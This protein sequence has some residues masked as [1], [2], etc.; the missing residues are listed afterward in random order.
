[1]ILELLGELK[2]AYEELLPAGQ[3]L[4]GVKSVKI[5]D[6]SALADRELPCITLD[7]TEMPAP[8]GGLAR[9]SREEWSF[10]VQVALFSADAR[11]GVAQAKLWQLLT[12]PSPG[13][14]YGLRY[15]L[16]AFT[17]LKLSSGGLFLL[18]PGP[19]RL[20][21]RNDRSIFTAGAVCTVVAS[22]WGA[23]P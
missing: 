18:A 1:M 12:P 10:T 14:Q 23:Q 20:G 4:H 6:F 7:C 3:A 15:V 2:E 13:A 17:Q 9:G 5:G 8:T 11:P 19:I 21:A 22:T 16:S